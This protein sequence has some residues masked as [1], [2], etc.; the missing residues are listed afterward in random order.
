MDPVDQTMTKLFNPRQ[1]VW[2]DH[3]RWNGPLL[4]GLSA[5]GRATIDVLKINLPKRLATRLNVMTAGTFFIQ[6]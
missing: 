4:Q 6:T 3:F 1:D 5:E 2:S